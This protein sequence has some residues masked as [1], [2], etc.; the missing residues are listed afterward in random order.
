[1]ALRHVA[2][3]DWTPGQEPDP[4]EVEDLLREIVSAHQGTLQLGSSL[5]LSPS[6]YSYG[7]T[8]DFPSDAAYTAYLMDPRH[9]D[10]LNDV[11]RPAARSICAIQIPLDS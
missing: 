11:L 9:Q 2:L 8:A 1:M 3:F 7:L 10:L 6:T 4:H 5:G